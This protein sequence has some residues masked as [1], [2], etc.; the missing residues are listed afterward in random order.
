MPVAFVGEAPQMQQLITGLDVVGLIG[1]NEPQLDVTNAAQLERLVA[2]LDGGLYDLAHDIGI[3]LCR[4]FGVSDDHIDDDVLEPRLW[5]PWWPIL[6]AVG[7]KAANCRSLSAA[8][9]GA[10]IPAV[11]GRRARCCLAL[12]GL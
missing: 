11:I 6:S 8:C 2:R 1:M 7:L 12:L 10:C 4:G 9:A 3:A 5:V